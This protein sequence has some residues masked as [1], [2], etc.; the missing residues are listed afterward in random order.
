M[1]RFLSCLLAVAT[2]I[3]L[4]LASASAQTGTFKILHNFT[5]GSDGAYPVTP[6][7]FDK[8]G[9]L[10]GMTGDGGFGLRMS[11][12]RMRHSVR[13]VPEKRA[14]GPYAD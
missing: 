1:R 14:L 10:Y 8:A 9:N 6:L 2:M 4:L 11:P 13:D 7:A 3:S 5:N 12:L